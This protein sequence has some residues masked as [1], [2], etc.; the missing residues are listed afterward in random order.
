MKPDKKNFTN[1]LHTLQ[2]KTKLNLSNFFRAP[3]CTFDIVRWDAASYR[4]KGQSCVWRRKNSDGKVNFGSKT[5]YESNFHL[6][7]SGV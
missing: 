2:H 7:S 4:Y 3:Q 6:I 1:K 5:V